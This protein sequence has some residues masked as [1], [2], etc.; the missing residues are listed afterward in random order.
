[1]KRLPLAGIMMLAMVESLTAQVGHDP[2]KSPY[3]DLATKQSLSL[4]VGYLAGS[5]GKIGV[6]PA[7]G[8][9]A[10]LRYDRAVGGA[11]EV[12][13]AMSVADLER[14]A[15]DPNA[16]VSARTFGPINETLILLGAGMHVVLPGRK[17]WHRLAPYAGVGFGIAFQT[18]LSRDLS[19]YEFGSK[20]YLA[21]TFGIKWYPTPAVAVKVEARDFLW[22][23]SYPN[24]F[25]TASGTNTEPVL[26]PNV[27][28]NTD[29]AHHA[30]VALSL[31]YTF[32]F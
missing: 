22:R 10:E 12:L 30:T 8:G 1:M 27:D 31:G 23:L 19:G 17:T 14:F 25:F 5:R 13:V 4:S 32:F 26:D 15:V 9:I 18:G 20:F 28:D 24:T 7:G 29:W 2:A 16:P 3:S 11:F 6:G 21:P